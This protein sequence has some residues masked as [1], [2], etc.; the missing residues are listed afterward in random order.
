MEEIHPL[1]QQSW[2]YPRWELEQAG[3]TGA[4]GAGTREPTVEN[5][6]YMR[7]KYRTHGLAISFQLFSVPLPAAGMHWEN[8]VCSKSHWRELAYA[9]VEGGSFISTWELRRGSNK[10]CVLQTLSQRHLRL[11]FVFTNSRDQVLNT[12]L[13]LL[14]AEGAKGNSVLN[15]GALVQC[16]C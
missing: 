2:R 16:S 9:G 13:F 11:V 1:Y 15:L 10:D 6:I 14:P 3:G 7:R 5:R 4:G 8:G 12:N